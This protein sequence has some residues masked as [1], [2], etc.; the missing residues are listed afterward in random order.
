MAGLGGARGL[1][2]RALERRREQKRHARVAEVDRELVG[3]LA[4]QVRGDDAR[5]GDEP[6]AS[7]SN[8]SPFDR[9][10]RIRW[11]GASNVPQRGADRE[12]V[13]RDRVVDVADARRTRR[14]SRAGAARRRSS[15]ARLRS[16]PRPRPHARA[17][18]T[19]AAAFARLCGPGGAARRAAGRRRRTRSRRSASGRSEARGTTAKS[20]GPWFSKIRSLARGRP[21][22]C[23]AGRGGRGSRLRSTATSGASS[24]TSSSWKLDTSQTIRRPARRADQLASARGRRCRADR[25][26]RGSRPSSSLVVVLPLVPV[27]ARI[28]F[29]EQPRAELDLAPDRDPALAR[30]GDER[31]LSRHA[32]ALD[33]RRRRRRAA[34]RSL[35]VAERPVGADD[36][37]AASPRARALRRPARAREPEHERA[38]LTA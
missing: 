6:R 33:E 4:D 15:A 2:H 18:A 16:R 7:S 3:R 19:A 22:A 30:G 17:A 31:R 21:R 11:I 27:T 12:D 32:R 35:V 34:T 20:S 23:R 25:R 29:V 5:L 37:G 14:P 36:L 26:A 28:G 10:P 8:G 24:C 38:V 13:R 1:G 9:P